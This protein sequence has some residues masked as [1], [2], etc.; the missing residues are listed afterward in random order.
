MSKQTSGPKHCRVCG[1]PCHWPNSARGGSRSGKGLCK[2]HFEQAMRVVSRSWL[3]RRIRNTDLKDDQVWLREPT[4][5]DLVTVITEPPTC[6]AIAW[7]EPCGE[8]VRPGKFGLCELHI[9]R[10]NATGQTMVTKPGW[11]RYRESDGLFEDEDPRTVITRPEFIECHGCKGN[12][13]DHEW[14][15][16]VPPRPTRKMGSTVTVSQRRRKRWIS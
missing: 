11:A 6:P 10:K 5:E 15:Q 7:G 3:A 1:D 9:S 12:L 8:P 4:I 14:G 2:A 16:C 13:M